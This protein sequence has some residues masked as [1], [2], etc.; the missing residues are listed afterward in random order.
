M[1]S[2]LGE[3]VIS[4]AQRAR[5]AATRSIVSAG[6]SPVSTPCVWVSDSSTSPLGNG[7]T[8]TSPIATAAITSAKSLRLWRLGVGLDIPS[9]VAARVLGLRHSFHHWIFAR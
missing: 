9:T 8:T 3:T 7:S 5:Q 6:M 2:W 1:L 4:A